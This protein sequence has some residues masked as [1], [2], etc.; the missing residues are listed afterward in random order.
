M[1]TN[2]MNMKEMNLNELEQVS[3]GV[4]R[5]N[6]PGGDGNIISWIIDFF[7]GD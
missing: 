2:E 7:T 6:A 5:E 1:N 4:D 3:G